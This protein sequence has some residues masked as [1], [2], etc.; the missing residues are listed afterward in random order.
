[1]ITRR[2]VIAASSATIAFGATEARS[3]IAIPT[4]EELSEAVKNPEEYQRVLYE[5]D[6]LRLLLILNLWDRKGPPNKKEVDLYQEIR[7]PFNAEGSLNRIRPLVFKTDSVKLINTAAI[8]AQ[9]VAK[10]MQ[11]FLAE[12][13]VAS[14]KPTS[15]DAT[16]GFY[17]FVQ[18]KAAA[19]GKVTKWYCE[20]YPFSYFC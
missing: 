11:Q 2:A 6:L 5:V 1:M 7:R 14:D 8:S 10:K 3:Q 20:V 13:G 4:T 17:N 12:R 16:R 9:P 19:D 18:L 15:H